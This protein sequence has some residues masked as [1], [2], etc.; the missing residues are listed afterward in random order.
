VSLPVEAVAIDGDWIRHAPPGSD[1]LGRSATPSDGRWQHGD[2]VSALYLADSAETAT[3]EWYRLLAEHGFYPEDYRPFDYHRWHLALDL[4]DLSDRSRLRAVGLDQPRPGRRTWPKFQ[5]VG[6]QLWRDGWLGLIAPSAARPESLIACVFIA[7]DWPPTG[8][9][10]L[11]AI[12]N[13][14]VPPPPRGMTT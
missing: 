9:Q 1:L 14:R 4:G 5:D 8:S 10:P 12:T 13:D 3:A 7:D 6:E 11:E 2:T